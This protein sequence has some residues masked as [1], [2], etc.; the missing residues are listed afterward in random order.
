ME[1]LSQK[2][3]EQQNPLEKMFHPFKSSVGE[4]KIFETY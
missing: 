2:W 4:K 3:I 1:K